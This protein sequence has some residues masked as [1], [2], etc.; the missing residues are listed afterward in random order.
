MKTRTLLR[1]VVKA[2]AM[3]TALERSLLAQADQQAAE[4]AWR[5]DLPPNPDDRAALHRFLD[6]AARA[7]ASRFP[8]G[9]E[10][11]EKSLASWA[12]ADYPGKR[13]HERNLALELAEV[14]G[15]ARGAAQVDQ[16]EDEQERPE[17]P[18]K[19]RRLQ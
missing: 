14:R 4:E 15:E 10:P 2:E 19:T 9:F 7:F 12:N 17:P 1:R 6:R 3:P 16:A 8:P 18:Q 5:D 11:L 13:E